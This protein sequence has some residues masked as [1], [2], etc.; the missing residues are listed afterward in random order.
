MQEQ[1]ISKSEPGMVGDLERVLVPQKRD[2]A[3]FAAGSTQNFW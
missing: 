2:W 3:L 1:G